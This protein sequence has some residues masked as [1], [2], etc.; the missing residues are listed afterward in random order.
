M[1]LS[2]TCAKSMTELL[3]PFAEIP[4]YRQSMCQTWCDLVFT[5]Q[6]M[7]L[8]VAMESPLRTFRYL[9]NLDFFNVK[10]GRGDVIGYIQ[11][12]VVLY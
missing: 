6:G 3:L 7:V 10:D 4:I 8:D 5:V 11:C 1:G 12:T 9:E 2:A